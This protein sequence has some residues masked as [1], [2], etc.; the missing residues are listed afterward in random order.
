M[1]RH[2]A[3]TME[4]KPRKSIV[5]ARFLWLPSID[6]SWQF[7]SGVDC[8]SLGPVAV[9]SAV[10]RR[11]H[12]LRGSSASFLAFDPVTLAALFQQGILLWIAHH[13]LRDVG[14]EQVVQPG[15]PSSFFKRD[16][17]VSA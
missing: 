15:G 1:G 2:I 4:I 13:D 9:F 3:R 6:L 8:A 10:D 12:S 7:R 17:Q 16:G 14:L 11:K 5:V